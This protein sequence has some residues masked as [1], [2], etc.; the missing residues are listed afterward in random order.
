MPSRFSRS[1]RRR[2]RDSA[3]AFVCGGRLSGL[4]LLQVLPQA[5]QA[6]RVLA[7]EK[8]RREVQG[9]ERPGEGPQLRLVKLQAHHLADAELHTVE[10]HRPVLLQMR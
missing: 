1:V 9:V 7:D 8:L 5:L 2:R 6:G 4:G 10:T 3:A